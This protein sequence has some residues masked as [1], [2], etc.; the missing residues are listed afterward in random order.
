MLLL[1]AMRAQFLPDV[2]VSPVRV[3]AGSGDTWFTVAGIGLTPS[4]Q[5]YWNGNPQPTKYVSEWSVKTLM[6][7]AAMAH[8]GIAKIWLWD[9][10]QGARASNTVSIPIYL[11]L[12][13]QDLVYDSA[14]ARLYASL[15][16]SDANGPSIAVIEPVQGNVE[17]YIPLPDEPWVMAL[18]S[19]GQYLYVAMSDRIRR[20]DLSAGSPD[21]D[22]PFQQTAA[23]ILPLP[24][25]GTSFVVTFGSTIY[26]AVVFD[27]ATQRPHQSND[28]PKC[29]V[30]IDGTALYG[31]PEFRLLRLGANGLPYSAELEVDSLLGGFDCPVYAG[32]ILYGSDG[33]IVDPAAPAVVGRFGGAGLVDV[34]L[35]RN[36]AYFVQGSS[37][38]ENI[39]VFDASSH[40][41]LVSTD[42]PGKWIMNAGR[43]VHWGSD[44]LAFIDFSGPNGIYLVHTGDLY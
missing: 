2:T 25:D 16:T 13:S 41:L 15:L 42:L 1:P 10:D 5:V 24:G 14:R 43:L 33:E 37:T 7:A 36:E 35:D 4:V 30:A 27:G 6:P 22:I 29:L 31:G 23:S 44:G 28:A 26:S 18:T 21:L 8:P 20:I 38:V 32:G 19:S 17:R 12:Q 39:S 11:P 34:A 40:A 3:A 9:P